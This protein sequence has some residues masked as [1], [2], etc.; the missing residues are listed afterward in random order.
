MKQH[1]LLSSQ[2]NVKLNKGDRFSVQFFL[3]DEKL[4]E[5]YAPKFRDLFR[6]LNAEG[7]ESGASSIF[8]SQI[9]FSELTV[10]QESGGNQ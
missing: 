4:I 9:A 7:R 6:Q 5:K 1:S 10:R 8:A 3:A 2:L